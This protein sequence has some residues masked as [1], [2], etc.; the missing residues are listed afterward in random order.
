MD[1]GELMALLPARQEARKNTRCKSYLMTDG[2][3]ERIECRRRS[4]LV[5]AF[6]ISPSVR[7]TRQKNVVVAKSGEEIKFFYI[8]Q[9]REST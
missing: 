6:P 7:I 8:V 4:H 3:V 5:L 1:L 9:S 2:L